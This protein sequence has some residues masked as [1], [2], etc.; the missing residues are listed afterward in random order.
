MA[1]TPYTSQQPRVQGIPQ[2]T[3]QQQIMPIT[4]PPS[5]QRPTFGISVT[6]TI[7]GSCCFIFGIIIIIV[8]NFPLISITGVNIW[9]GLFYL[10][11]GILG[12]SHTKSPT[13]I[14]ITH[15]F[16][17]F[18]IIGFIF[19]FPHLGLAI[20]S[21]ATY[22]ALFGAISLVFSLLALS[23][24]LAFIIILSQ[25]IYCRSSGQ[26][27]QG[28]YSN[29]TGTQP[30]TYQV[31]QPIQ[32]PPIIANPNMPAGAPLQ[33]PPMMNPQPTDTSNEKSPSGLPPPY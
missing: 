31:N 16:Y 33:P 23:L 22:G 11:A 20:A 9:A 3:P 17:A 13:N 15:A 27:S 25:H 32:Q 4:V 12:I 26:F 1:A 18:N 8:S 19:S 2:Y 14:S 30:V 10:I 21:L 28:Q 6:L 7:L 24:T 29:F 5:L